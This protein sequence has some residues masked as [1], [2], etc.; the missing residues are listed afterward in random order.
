M[1]DGVFVLMCISFRLII[2]VGVK[3]IDIFITASNETGIWACMELETDA[4]DK[5]HEILWCCGFDVTLFEVGCLSIK[6]VDIKVVGFYK[7]YRIVAICVA[8]IDHSLG[9]PLSLISCS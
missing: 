4:K 6:E 2:G 9:R 5:F 8:V 7:L 1:S 3:S